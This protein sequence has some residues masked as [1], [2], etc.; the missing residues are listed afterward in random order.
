MLLGF[1]IDG[2]LTK[3]SWETY[4]N[5]PDYIKNIPNFTPTKILEHLVEGCLLRNEN[6]HVITFRHYNLK[7]ITETWFQKH[8]P[9]DVIN[10]YITFK[11]TSIHIDEESIGIPEAF[12]LYREES[13]QYKAINIKSNNLDM[14]FEDDVV[15]YNNLVELCPKCT[16]IL[17]QGSNRCSI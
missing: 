2:V 3:E 14:Y 11:Y 4:M 12:K 6:I 15:I 16:I 8:I 1:D 7:S 9:K 5:T 17:V 13:S 10:K